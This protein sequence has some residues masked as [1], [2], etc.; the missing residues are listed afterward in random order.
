LGKKREFLQLLLK[1]HKLFIELSNKFTTMVDPTNW[2]YYFKKTEQGNGAS[3]LHCNWTMKRSKDKST[4][5][6][7]YHLEHSHPPQFSQKL[8]AERIKQKEKMKVRG[9]SVKQ[10]I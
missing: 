9:C 1:L 10:N 7:K 2:W 4:K 6:L 5:G 8:E 3:C